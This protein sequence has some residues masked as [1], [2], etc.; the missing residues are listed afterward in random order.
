MGTKWAPTNK[1]TTSK[2]GLKIC[3]DADKTGAGDRT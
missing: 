2:G 3:T 1:K